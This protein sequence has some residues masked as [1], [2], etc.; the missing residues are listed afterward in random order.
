[1]EVS[2]KGFKL[3]ETMYG[4][5]VVSPFGGK[6]YHFKTIDIKMIKFCIDMAFRIRRSEGYLIIW[7]KRSV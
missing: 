1:M 4:I 5:S 2:H 3:R 6:E 7:E